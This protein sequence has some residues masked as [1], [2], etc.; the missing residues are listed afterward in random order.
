MLSG[1]VYLSKSDGTEQ[2]GGVLDSLPGA[3]GWIVTGISHNFADTKL[4]ALAQCF[5]PAS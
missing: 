4:V 3:E 2:Q 5:L 1:G